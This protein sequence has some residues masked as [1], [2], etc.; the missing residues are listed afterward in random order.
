MLGKWYHNKGRTRGIDRGIRDER[1]IMST[2]EGGSGWREVGERERES[3]LERQRKSERCWNNNIKLKKTDHRAIITQS[4]LWDSIHLLC[5]HQLLSCFLLFILSNITLL[6]YASKNTAYWGEVG[7][8]RRWLLQ[9]LHQYATGQGSD[10]SPTTTLLD[11]WTKQVYFSCVRDEYSW[12]S[13]RAGSVVR[14]HTGL[15]VCV[16]V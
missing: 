7:K 15:P 5:I 2:P 10:F 1:C 16:F 4:H 14:E 9:N 6:L 12:C 13:E 8:T 11:H 3:E